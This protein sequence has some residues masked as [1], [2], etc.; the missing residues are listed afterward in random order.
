MLLFDPGFHF[1]AAVS[2]E[3]ADSNDGRSIAVLEP[4]AS[5]CAQADAEPC[6]DFLLAEQ[7]RRLSAQPSP[8]G[9]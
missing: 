7:R 3:P 2:H 9:P 1:T 6:S 8:L 5:K 4:P